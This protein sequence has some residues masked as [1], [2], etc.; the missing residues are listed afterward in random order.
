MQGQCL[1]GEV[2]FEI[3]GDLPNLYQCHCSLCRKTTG[4]SANAATL[5][6]AGR[7]RWTGGE[8][9]ISSYRRPTGYRS[10]FC[11][12]CGSP[13]PNPVGGSGDVWVPAG[14]LEG[15]AGA[16]VAVHLHLASR[17]DWDPGIGQGAGIGFDAAADLA[18]LKRAL[19]RPACDPQHPASGAADKNMGVQYRTNAPVSADQFIALLKTSSLAERRPVHDRACMEG[20]L[21][22]ANLTVSAWEGEELVGISRSVTDFHY[23]C[24]L[25]DLAVS[26][27]H[28]RLGIGNGLVAHTREQL[29][30][31]CKLILIAAPAAS[32]YY[33][34][35]GFAHNDRCW[36]LDRD[37]PLRG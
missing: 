1:C 18:T 14:L 7:F 30:P 24:Y 37:S 16:R 19:E 25:S 26:Q 32:D 33:R 12:N 15:E 34:H 22:N 28:Q 10:D 35:I 5:V 13:V 8:A 9:R 31:Q 20:M 36:V 11:S 27:S 29:G 17:A 23:A 6:P 3:E 21:A 2:R 4:S